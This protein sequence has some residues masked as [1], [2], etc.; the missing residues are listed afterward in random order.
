M[1]SA[2]MGGLIVPDLVVEGANAF[3]NSAS[4]YDGAFAASDC[5]VA[6]ITATEVVV[7][8]PA[9]LDAVTKTVT[10][11]ARQVT[12]TGLN[13]TNASL[14]P[15]QRLI[16][17]TPIAPYAEDRSNINGWRYRYMVVPEM[18]EDENTIEPAHPTP[19]L[20]AVGMLC[21][22]YYGW[23]DG[24]PLLQRTVDYLSELGPSVAADS[25]VAGPNM[26]YNY[27]ATQVLRHQSNPQQWT[28]WNEELR[29]FLIESQELTGHERG[30]W[31]FGDQTH[32]DSHGG[33]LY[34]TAL[35][36]MI[37]E[38]YYRHLPLYQKNVTES[39]LE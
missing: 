31:H 7:N 29:D 14:Q 20:T 9:K 3:L 16:Q 1:K 27:Y 11:A 36:C 17:G 22:M 18:K 25:K 37:L 32:G 38:V 30:S 5:T 12:Y 24:N 35:A 2:K 21:R 34:S 39:V 6:G 26:Y 13:T 8:I 33:R 28:A 15:G 23:E 10:K 19:T 4:L